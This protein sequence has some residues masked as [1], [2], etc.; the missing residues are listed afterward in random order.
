VVIAAPAG[1]T[2][3]PGIVDPKVSVEVLRKRID[4]D[5]RRM[6]H[7]AIDWTVTD[8][9]LIVASA[10]FLMEF[11]EYAH[12]AEVLKANLRK[13][14]ATDGWAHESLAIALQMGQAAP[15]E[16]ERA[17]VS[18]IDLDPTSPK[19]YLKAA[20]VEA[21]L[22]NHD[23]A[24]A[25]CKRAA[26]FS[27]NEPEPYAN[28][29]VYAE[30]AKA[31][32]SDTVD[33]AAANLLRRD[34]PADGVDY[35]RK[36]KDLLPKFVTRFEAAGAKADGLRRTLTEQTQRDLVIELVWQGPADL[37]LA[38]AEPCGSVCS[39]TK[40]R[41][42]GG[43]VL[44]ADQ[45]DQKDDP[46]GGGGRSEVYTAASAF[47]GTY[48][49][50]VRKAFGQPVGNAAT[51]KVYRFK[52]TPRESFDLVPV[53][54]A[55]GRPVELKLDG[56]SRADLAVVH[57]EPTEFKLETT[58]SPVT[59]G[60]SGMGGGVGSAGSAMT[61]PVAGTK[62]HDSALPVVVPPVEVREPGIGGAAD[63]RASFKLNPDR[64]S[65]SVRV[66]PVF[67]TAGGKDVP[68]PRVPLLPGGEQ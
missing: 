53:D 22:G 59:R 8:P 6:W 55:G 15:A 26:R 20:Q 67:A 16:V 41:T 10:E 63:L 68:L 52:G 38:V 24:V 61:T 28:A 50:T 5:P 51:L 58:G 46:N 25:F 40:R 37:D 64:Q 17:A 35:H 9:G 42:A 47:S 11:D 2:G 36:A 13:G 21:D 14:L 45:L 39:P 66:D 3:K 19:A 54:L 65:Y 33:W 44:R 1:E 27:P 7:Q 43:G 34:W 60:P 56:G 4:N 32:T 23:R 57:E 49:V 29:L 12:A 48:K 31:V 62:V 30:K 18:A